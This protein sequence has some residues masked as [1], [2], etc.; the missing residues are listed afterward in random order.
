[1]ASVWRRR[2]PVR[3]PST[4]RTTAP[5]AS[6]WENCAARS[7]STG[8]PP[9]PRASRSASGARLHRL[10]YSMSN[11]PMNYM[12]PLVRLSP[13]DFDAAL[14]DLDG[15]LTR[16]AELHAAAWKQLFDEF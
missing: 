16:T 8:R 7:S 6:R 14:F 10:R 9:S 3:W 2:W 13:R 4:I 1:M 5:P 11:D 15:V 12:N